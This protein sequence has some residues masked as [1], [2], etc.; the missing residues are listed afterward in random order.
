[1]FKQK[2]VKLI[3]ARFAKSANLKKTNNDPHHIPKLAYGEKM[4]KW[5]YHPD[6]CDHCGS[7]TE[8]F[9]DEGLEEGYGFDGDEMRCVECGAIGQWVVYDE[10][11]A[12]SRWD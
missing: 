10:D 4:K 11:E 7:G 2:L 6:Q 1:L 3:F 9:T 12:Y 5:K 8:I